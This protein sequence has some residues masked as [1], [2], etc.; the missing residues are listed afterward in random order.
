MMVTTVADVVDVCAPNAPV[1]ISDE[2]PAGRGLV[3]TRDVEAGSPLLD[4]TPA[5]LINARTADTWLHKDLIPT[6]DRPSHDRHHTNDRLS[7]AQSLAEVLL[8]LTSYQILSILLARWKTSPP[9]SDTR[10]ATFVESLPK[11]FPTCPVVWSLSEKTSSLAALLPNLTAE[12]CRQVQAKF[13]WDW[14]AVQAVQSLRPDLLRD[15]ESGSYS[16]IDLHTFAWAWCCVNS[17]CVYL[18]LGLRPHSDNFTL[19]PVLDMCNHTWQKTDECKVTWTAAAGLQLRAPAL[20]VRPAGLKRNDEILISYGAHSNGTLLS[21]YGFVLGR[22]KGENKV[23]EASWESGNPFVEVRLDEYVGAL[24]DTCISSKE[25]GE[26]VIQL[27]QENGYWRDYTIHPHPSPAHPSHRLVVALR[28]LAA[29]DHSSPPLSS[30]PSKEVPMPAQGLHQQRSSGRQ[31]AKKATTFN[32]GTMSSD[33]TNK[34]A[35]VQAEPDVVQAWLEMTWG[36]RNVISSE[37]EA[38]AHELLVVLVKEA[39]QA[40]QSKLEKLSGLQSSKTGAASTSSD[41]LEL[42]QTILEEEVDTCQ[43]V[44]DLDPS[45]NAW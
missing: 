41:S 21:E 11:A 32:N 9:N 29:H 40:A 25:A 19:A 30:R 15:P 39:Q 31:K 14:A 12:L 10:L 34:A 23:N 1:T 44:L 17:R 33:T 16:P 26:D 35:G 45:A 42:I 22:R 43:A 13:E 5:T 38:R 18:P 37:N 8:P 28:L 24:L 2:V 27:L 20:S 7:Q 36:Q 4:L 3:L 6:R